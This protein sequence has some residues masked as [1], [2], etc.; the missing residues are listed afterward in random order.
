[1]DG[2][3]KLH[4]NL[5]APLWRRLAAL[6]YDSVILTALAFVIT[7]LYTAIFAL[8]FGKTAEAS[9]SS[10]LFLQGILFPLLLINLIGFYIF[11]WLKNKAT[12]GMQTWKIYLVTCN[13]TALTWQHCLKRC[14]MAI[15]SLSCIGLGYFWQVWDKNKLSWHDHFSQTKIVLKQSK[16]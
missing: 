15:L 12:L 1:M 4:D 2:N 9:T 6:L 13:G 10:L 3:T 11:F 7:A 5:I 8:I 14:L 16:K